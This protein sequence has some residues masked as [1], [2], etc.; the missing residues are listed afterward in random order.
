[1]PNR[2]NYAKRPYPNRLR[3]I[4][5]NEEPWRPISGHV[6]RRCAVCRFWFSATAGQEK[7]RDCEAVT[8][9]RGQRA[10]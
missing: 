3:A 1:M 9:K 4:I 7:C 6:K 2:T 10:D 5:D 8:R